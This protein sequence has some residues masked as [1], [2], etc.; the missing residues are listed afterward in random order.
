[1]KYIV[2]GILMMMLWMAPACAQ[3]TQQD[4]SVR[5][6][7]LTCAPGEELYALFGHT[8]IRYEEPRRGIDVV[9]NYGLFSFRTP[10]FAL[11]FALGETDYMLGA[12]D[13]DSFMAEYMMTNRSV[14]QQT[15]NLTPQEKARL[16]GMLEENYRPENR[17]YRYNF[18]YDNCAT[19]PRDKIKESI[20]GKVVF[21]KLTEKQVSFR[22]MVRLHT[23][24]HAWARFGFNLCLGARADLPITDE[25]MMFTPHFLKEAFDG[26]TIETNG[27]TRPLVASTV[28]LYEQEPETE[29]EKEAAAERFTPVGVAYLLLLVCI[30]LTLKDIRRRKGCWAFDLLL[31]A[32][33]GLAGCILAFLALFSSHPAVDRNYVLLVLHPGHLLMLPY[34]VYCIRK[35]KK[36]WYLVANMAVLT[37]FIPFSRLI[38]QE[39]EPAIVPLALCLLVRSAGNLIITYRKKA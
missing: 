20:D 31:F 29:A 33:A 3:A 28:T 19:R 34:I 17:M 27:S 39:F 5:I 11:R 25:Q 1:M 30:F 26:A 6:S 32:V 10:N 13:Y 24:G 8:A 38:P 2:T 14:W 22:D 36:C 16:I 12:E 7:L 18:F 15:L 9:F 21:P 23:E 35:G 37:L 4:D